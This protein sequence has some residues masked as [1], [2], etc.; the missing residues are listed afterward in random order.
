MKLKNVGA[1]KYF[2]VH[3]AFMAFVIFNMFN[4]YI[5]TIFKNILKGFF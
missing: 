1:S 3:L 2:V 4:I 5:K